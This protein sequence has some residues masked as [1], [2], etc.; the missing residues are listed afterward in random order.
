M[1]AKR[2]TAPRKPPIVDPSP[3]LPG[4]I[5]MLK[6]VRPDGSP[7]NE[8]AR[9]TGFRWPLVVGSVVE[10]EKWDPQPICGGGLHGLPWGEGRADLLSTDADAVWLVFAAPA[11]EV[12]AITEEEGGKSKA[13]RG[14]VRY[15]GA[16]DEAVAYLLAHGAAGRAVV[17]ATVTGGDWATVTGGDGATVTGGDGA[18][19][20]GGDGATVTGGDRAT[21][22]GGVDGTIIVRHWDGKR[23]RTH[24]GYIGEDGVE[25]GVAYRW[26]AEA[27]RFVKA[28]SP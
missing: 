11:D 25:A 17:W 13:P 16:R 26:D 21:V 20:T 3:P 23:S 9:A 15:V 28:V 10:C 18:T 5:L 27:A 8:R 24:V 12:V 22:T 4:E 6:T 2:K 7:C 14:V 1:T 19:V